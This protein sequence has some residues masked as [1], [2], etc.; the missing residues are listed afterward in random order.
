MTNEKLT[1]KK[2]VAIVVLTV[3]LGLGGYAVFFAIIIFTSPF[4]HPLVS[5]TLGLSVGLAPTLALL[6]FSSKKKRKEVK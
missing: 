1:V 3:I 6:A 4:L 5:L 2:A